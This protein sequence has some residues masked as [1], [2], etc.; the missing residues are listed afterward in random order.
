MKYKIHNNWHIK[1][2]QIMNQKEYSEIGS[3]LLYLKALT[4]V[5]I[6]HL[7]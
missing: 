4:H 1:T 2:N 5:S 7:N 6:R 3:K